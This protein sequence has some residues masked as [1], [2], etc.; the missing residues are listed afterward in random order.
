MSCKIELEYIIYIF[1]FLLHEGYVMVSR[2]GNIYKYKDIVI[3]TNKCKSD[4]EY[5]K[6]IDVI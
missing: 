1:Y 2:M 3:K 5:L 4:L 6:F